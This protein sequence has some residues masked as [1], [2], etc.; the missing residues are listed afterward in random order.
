MNN[1]IL[2]IF[3]FIAGMLLHRSRRMPENTPAVFN[4]FIIHVSLPA[5]TL[6]HVHDLKLTSEVALLAAMGWLCFGLSAG[7]FWL[8]GRWLKLPRGTIGA[9]ILTGGLCNTAFFGLPMIDVYYG[10]EG[11]LTGLIVDQLGS[12]LVL[13]TLAVVVAGVYSSGR[14]TPGQMVRRIV[15]FP[16][17]IALVITLLLIPVAYPAWLT[18]LLKR[19]GDTLPPLALLAVGFQFRFGHIAGNMRNLALGLGFKLILAPLLLFILYVPV[20]GAHGQSIQIVLFQAA[21]PPMI[22]S[23][24]LASEHDLDPELATL[25]VAMGIL[26]SF[27]TLSGWWWVL[28]GV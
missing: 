1:L 4:G 20:L 3:C 13:S 8:M 10:H 12:F 19:L 6:L 17:F 28:Q 25:M 18:E 27:V 5:L 11:I 26:L 2:L 15:L 21:M 23:A 14:T 7:F 9:L 16:P 22:T 24:I